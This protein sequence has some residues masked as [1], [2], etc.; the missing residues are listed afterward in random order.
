MSSIFKIRR[1]TKQISIS[2][3]NGGDKERNPFTPQKR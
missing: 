3:T 2:I 1:K